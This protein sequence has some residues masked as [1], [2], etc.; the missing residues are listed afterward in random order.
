MSACNVR[1]RDRLSYEV[2]V[3]VDGVDGAKTMQLNECLDDRTDA[4]STASVLDMPRRK[5][6]C[7]AYVCAACIVLVLVATYSAYRHYFEKKYHV[8]YHTPSAM[9]PEVFVDHYVANNYT[10][11]TGSKLWGTY[12]ASMNPLPEGGRDVKIW[13]GGTCKEYTVYTAVETQCVQSSHPKA[14][15]FGEYDWEYIHAAIDPDADCKSREAMFV[16]NAYNGS[17]NLNLYDL[18]CDGERRLSPTR[19]RIIF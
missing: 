3:S 14:C 5:L 7:R 12:S 13:M 17:E 8:K 6:V 9:L 16:S 11:C 4:S 2:Q 19:K 18:E 10:S 1:P 15:L